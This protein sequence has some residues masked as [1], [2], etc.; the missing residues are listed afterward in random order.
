MCRLARGYADH[1]EHDYQALLATVAQ[2]VLHAEA[3]H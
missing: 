3:A 2:G 1:T